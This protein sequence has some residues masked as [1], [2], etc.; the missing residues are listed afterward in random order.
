MPVMQ[1]VRS[2]WTCGWPASEPHTGRRWRHDGHSPGVTINRRRFIAAIGAAGLL[3]LARSLA[4]ASCADAPAV[5]MRSL[6]ERLEPAIDTLTE[7]TVPSDWQLLHACLYYALAGQYL[8]ARY[9]IGTRLIGGAVVYFPT[10]P[11]YHRIKPHV[12][13]ETAGYYIDCA[14]LPRWGLVVVLPFRQVARDPVEI[15]P[16][17]T[18]VL[19]LEERNDPEFV[20]YVARHRV[21]FERILEGRNPDRD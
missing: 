19:I 14:A 6:L 16:G 10:S 17:L 3:A 2:T 4:A 18:Q 11:R 1:P 8:L 9:G 20:D 5:Q 12:W 21:R 15:V 13:L 7:R